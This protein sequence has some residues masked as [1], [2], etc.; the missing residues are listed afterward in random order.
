MCSVIKIG[1]FY[2]DE[3]WARRAFNEVKDMMLVNRRLSC[4][5]WCNEKDMFCSIE[6]LIL[7]KAI[8]A[9][10][11]NRRFRVDKAIIQPDLDEKTINEIIRPCTKSSIVTLY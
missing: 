2:N 5:S 6:G 8:K 9:N 7:I 10:G 4:A 11:C 3:D 1:I